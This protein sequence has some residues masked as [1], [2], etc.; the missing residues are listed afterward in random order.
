VPELRD[1]ISDDRA[2]AAKEHLRKLGRE[3]AVACRAV[4]GRPGAWK[5]EVNG[6]PTGYRL[7]RRGDNW[8]AERSD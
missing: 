5:V 1:S 7:V 8:L 3:A 6:H 4:A 2:R